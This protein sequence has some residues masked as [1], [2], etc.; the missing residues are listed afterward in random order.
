MSECQDLIKFYTNKYNINSTSCCG[1]D[2]IPSTL[3]EF[4][5]VIYI[6]D[7]WDFQIAC[8]LSG[9]KKV[10]MT[11]YDKFGDPEDIEE[12]Y[13]TT[14]KDDILRQ[15]VINYGIQKAEDR[16]GTEFW[17]YPQ[18]SVNANILINHYNGI[19]EFP[20][21]YFTSI[22]ALLLGYTEISYILYEMFNNSFSYLDQS[23]IDAYEQ[24]Y[25]QYLTYYIET[26]TPIVKFAKEWILSRKGII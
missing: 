8:V 16:S 17:V 12:Y 22:Q 23:N 15:N 4:L 18:Y 7:E 19:D 9:M 20:K 3:K 6:V 13:S 2:Y 25:Q 10:A 26:Y 14:P 21:G 24:V 5:D 11:D 1:P